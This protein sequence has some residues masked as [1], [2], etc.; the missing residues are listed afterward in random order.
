MRKCINSLGSGNIDDCFHTCNFVREMYK[1]FLSKFNNYLIY[2][3]PDYFIISVV[4]SGKGHKEIGRKVYVLKQSLHK[5]EM[6]CYNITVRGSE[7]PKHMLAS[8]VSTDNHLNPEDDEGF[9]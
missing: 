6:V 5:M 2:N 1:G 9:Y 7:V 8:V 3:H 4:G